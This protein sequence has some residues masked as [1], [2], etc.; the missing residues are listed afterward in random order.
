MTQ[1]NSINISSELAYDL[2][3]TY[4]KILTDDLIK[5]ADARE[6]NDFVHWFEFIHWNLHTEINQ[7]FNSAEKEEYNKLLDE[8]IKVLNKNKPAFLGQDT[9]AENVFAIK[10]ALK[11]LETWIKE[12]M[13]EHSMYGNK[14]DDEGF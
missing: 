14:W 9:Q 3:Q 5:I 11:K 7:K 12:K 10:N 6:R 2:R 1:D 13:E 4:A 8:T